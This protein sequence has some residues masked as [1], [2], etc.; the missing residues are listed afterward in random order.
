MTSKYSVKIAL[1]STRDSKWLAFGHHWSTTAAYCYT[2][3]TDLSCFDFKLLEPF[4]CPLLTPIRCLKCR[5][6]WLLCPL[7]TPDAHPQARASLWSS[8]HLSAPAQRPPSRLISGLL[9][10]AGAHIEGCWLLHGNGRGGYLFFPLGHRL[11][12]MDTRI[13]NNKSSM[14]RLAWGQC[15]DHQ[16]WWKWIGWHVRLL[17]CHKRWQ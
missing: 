7:L 13:Q 4:V 9:L 6:L 5:S 3:R 10:R 8:H 1:I 17:K 12:C 15:R 14:G 16:R 11:F 2:Q